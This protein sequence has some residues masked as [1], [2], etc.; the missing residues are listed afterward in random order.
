[1]LEVVGILRELHLGRD[2]LNG[3]QKNRDQM[4]HQDDEELVVVLRLLDL[5]DLDSFEYL[6]L[7]AN[8]FGALVCP[9]FF[10]VRFCMN[11]GLVLFSI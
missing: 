11:N 5:L 1:M 10:F 7:P 6:T 9:N 3:I 8:E 2:L 4:L